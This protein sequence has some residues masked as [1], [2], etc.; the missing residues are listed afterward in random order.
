MNILELTMKF[1]RGTLNFIFEILGAAAEAAEESAN[2]PNE[3][4][5]EP[6]HCQWNWRTGEYDMGEDPAGWY[7]ND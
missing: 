4:K 7:D 3:S 5:K 2:A 1:L 6:E